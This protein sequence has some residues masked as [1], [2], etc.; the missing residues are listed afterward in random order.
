MSVTIFELGQQLCPAEAARSSAKPA[1]RSAES[2]LEDVGTSDAS[3]G[4]EVS[5]FQSGKTRLE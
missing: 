3:L 4:E 2:Q 5:P 1:L